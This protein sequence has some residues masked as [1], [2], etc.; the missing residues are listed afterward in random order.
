MKGPV[1]VMANLKP[2]K[3]G[4][5]NS[6]GMV[7]AV[8]IADS[9]DL[10]IPPEGMPVGE[11][12]GVEGEFS[13][14]SSPLLPKLN[15]KKKIL[16]KCVDFLHTD[17]EGYACFGEKKLITSQGYIKTKYANSSIS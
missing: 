10:L 3:L 17:E 12:V 9:F 6:N 14:E 5:F 2:R 15:P 8:H 16:E 1:F 11:R 7:L 4:G 13:F